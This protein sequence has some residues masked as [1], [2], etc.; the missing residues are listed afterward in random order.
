MFKQLQNNLMKITS[1]DNSEQF[2]S[3]KAMEIL[4]RIGS[5]ARIILLYGTII[6]GGTFLCTRS[7]TIYECY[8]RKKDVI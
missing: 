3:S 4:S 6:G 2:A 8:K 7:Q 5:E 1:N